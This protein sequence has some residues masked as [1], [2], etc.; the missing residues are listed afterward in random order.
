MPLARTGDQLLV[1]DI[2]LSIILNTLR[3]AGPLSRA[4][5]ALK[6]GL[7]KTT[8]SSLINELVEARFVRARGYHGSGGGR[9]GMLLE[10]NPEAGCIIAAEIGVDFIS[11]ILSNFNAEILWRHQ[12]ETAS[13]DGQKETLQRAAQLLRRAATQ[14]ERFSARILGIA[15]GV[16]GLVDVQSG[17]LIF[18]PNLRWRDVPLKS[19][20]ESK[21]DGSIFVDNEAKMAALGETYFGVAR[22]HPNVLYLSAGVGLGGGMVLDG[23][24][25]PGASGFAGEFGHMTI[26]PDGLQCNCGNRG[27]WETLVSQWAVFRR[28]RNAVAAGQSSRLLGLTHGDLEH[29]TIPLIVEAAREGDGVACELLEQTG[30]YLGIGLANLINALNPEMVVFGGILSLAGDFLLPVMKRVIEERALLWTRRAVSI[31]VAAHGFDACVMGGIATVYHHILSQP[32]GL[33]K[34]VAAIK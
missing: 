30:E 15:V 14:A 33:R 8:V 21:F 23:R 7:N 25:V 1:R 12:E 13:R 16:P 2:N 19:M 28:A 22:G 31:V 18:A 10:L 34:S 26:E 17:T 20:L 6:T 11:L 27:C 9:P 5:L 29:L 32:K 24:I 4:S 3:I